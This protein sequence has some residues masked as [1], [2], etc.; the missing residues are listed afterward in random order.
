MTNSKQLLDAA[1]AFNDGFAIEEIS[2]KDLQEM[3]ENRFIAGAEYERERLAKADI[4]GFAQTSVDLGDGDELTKMIEI[5]AIQFLS[6]KLEAAQERLKKANELILFDINSA[7]DGAAMN[8]AAKL[9][10]YRKQL[11]QKG[12]GE[13]E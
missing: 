2:N 10:K 6:A 9:D 3:L 12:Q 1:R 7:S 4:E 11:T 13:N 8:H 5:S